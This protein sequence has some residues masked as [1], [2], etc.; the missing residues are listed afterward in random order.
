MIVKTILSDKKEHI[1]RDNELDDILNVEVKNDEDDGFS[2]NDDSGD[3]KN[4]GGDSSSLRDKDAELKKK[5]KSYL[6]NDTSFMIESNEEEINEI[7]EKMKHMGISKDKG[8]ELQKIRNM[9]K[10]I[11][12]IGK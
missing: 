12:T 11:R 2:D 8:L 9:N 1:V 7:I 10:G 6:S 3:D 5:I 4:S